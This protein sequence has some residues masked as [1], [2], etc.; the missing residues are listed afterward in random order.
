M[1]ALHDE[2]SFAAGSHQREAKFY[3]RAL[4]RLQNREGVGIAAIC[5][6]RRSSGTG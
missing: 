5:L 2:L 1:Q 4:N 6:S 3:L